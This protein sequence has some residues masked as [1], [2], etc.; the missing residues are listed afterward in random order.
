MKTAR[1]NTLLVHSTS[2]LEVDSIYTMKSQDIGGV[3]G[4]GEGFSDLSF[5]K[6]LIFS[7]DYGRF[8]GQVYLPHTPSGIGLIEHCL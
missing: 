4:R 8:R 5:W 3:V 7:T 2:I 6:I 1:E